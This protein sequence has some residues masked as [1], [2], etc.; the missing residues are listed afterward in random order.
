MK[1]PILRLA[2]CQ[3]QG[4]D[5][6][7]VES[8]KVHCSCRPTRKPRFQDKRQKR[9]DSNVPLKIV[10]NASAESMHWNWLW[11]KPGFT[12]LPLT[13]H[14]Q[15]AQSTNSSA[16]QR[17]ASIWSRDVTTTWTVKT[18]KMN[19]SVVSLPLLGVDF[20]SSSHKQFFT[21][22]SNQMKFTVLPFLF[23]RNFHM[24]LVTWKMSEPQ[25]RA[26]RLSVRLQRWL[27]WQLRWSKLPYVTRDSLDAT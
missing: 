11:D 13:R 23:S 1:F 17:F 7:V 10:L 2:S 19:S 8:Q 9:G 16:I 21:D 22:K 12:E 18:A 3:L 27:R 26:S 6:N 20:S 25:M 24:F 5:F 4:M 15:V 14:L